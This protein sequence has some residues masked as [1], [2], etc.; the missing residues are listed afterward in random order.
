MSF[1][2]QETTTKAAASNA[3]HPTQS[4]DLVVVGFGSTALSLATSLADSETPLKVLFLESKAAFD[5]APAS[6]L[7]ENATRTSFLRD[8]I[9][10]RNPRS[11]FTFVN[12]L[13]ESGQLVQFVN[14]SHMAPTRLVMGNYLTW[15]AAKMEEMEWVRYSSTVTRVVPVKIGASQISGWKIGVC[16]AQGTTSTIAC[17]RVVLATGS[18]PRI[19]DALTGAKGKV[20]HTSEVGPLLHNLKDQDIA[21]VG[22]DQEA[23]EIFEH[24]QSAGALHRV[25][26]TMFITDSAL[27]PEDNTS[28]VSLPPIL[29]LH[30][31]RLLTLAKL[32][33]QDIIDDILP[34]ATT[35]QYPPELRP[36]L[37]PPSS[38]SSQTSKISLRTIETLY[39]NL[40]AQ[41]ISTPKPSDWRF[42]IAPL[43]LVTS[44]IPSGNKLRLCLQNT[45]TNATS[46][47]PGAFDIV[48]AAGG[49]EHSISLLQDIEAAGVLQDKKA[50]VDAEYKLS[51]RRN[52]VAKDT[53]IWVMGS[54]DQGLRDEDMGYAVERSGRLLA[55]V[56]D[57]VA[58]SEEARG[59]VAML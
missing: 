58:G 29:S 9:T 19:P 47:S 30:T 50:A 31:Q 43:S 10:T 11:E 55:S 32:S 13:F 24:L 2:V 28:L 49:Y 59:E 17:K 36:R 23:A 53:G 27:R 46:T 4:Y 51:F 14:S 40:Y 52:A 42:T 45:R 20:L 21:I 15:V 48:I 22:A 8:L 37:L 34:G 57:S 18:K 39:E 25:R 5:W 35:S 12:Y 3:S 56:L 33:T 6:V 38:S 26:A 44:V 1:Q 7:P 41:R 54:L 16:D